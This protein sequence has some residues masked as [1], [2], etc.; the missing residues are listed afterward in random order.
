[1]LSCVCAALVCVIVHCYGDMLSCVCAALARVIVHCYGDMLSCVCAALVCVIVH[2]YGDMLSCVC[3]AFVRVAG[4]V[5]G[6][7]SVVDFSAQTAAHSLL[8]LL[9]NAQGSLSVASLL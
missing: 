3:A 9:H 8:P 2:C 1:M 4:D 6:S 7:C 5:Q